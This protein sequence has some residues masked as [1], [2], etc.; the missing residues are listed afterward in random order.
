MQSLNQTSRERLAAENLDTSPPATSAQTRKN[1][2][3]RYTLFGSFSSFFFFEKVLKISHSAGQNSKF[4]FFLA[5]PGQNLSEKRNNQSS[6]IIYD[7]I[8]ATNMLRNR[9]HINSPTVT[10]TIK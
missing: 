7:L 8:S 10:Q 6:C 2:I 3:T 9:K 1:K 4:N 5:N